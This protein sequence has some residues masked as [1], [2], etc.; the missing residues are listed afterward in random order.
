MLRPLYPLSTGTPSLVYGCF[1]TACLSLPRARGER[2][3]LPGARRASQPLLIGGWFTARGQAGR[4]NVECSRNSQ[5]RPGYRRESVLRRREGIQ[6][7]HDGPNGLS[8]ASFRSLRRLRSRNCPPSSKEPTM[9]RPHVHQAPRLV[10]LRPYRPCGSHPDAPPV[11]QGV[12]INGRTLPRCAHEMAPRR[13]RADTCAS[14]RSA[15]SIGPVPPAHGL[16]RQLSARS[17]RSAL[18]SGDRRCGS[19]LRRMLPLIP[20]V[21]NSRDRR[22]RGVRYPMM[23]CRR[24]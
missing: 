18:C 3:W 9:G 6:R 14:L 12:G 11:G 17:T 24:D 4:W 8:A 19:H 13:H 22:G 10:A 20:T 2:R 16:T 23:E 7:V 1:L 15:P 21:G 5:A